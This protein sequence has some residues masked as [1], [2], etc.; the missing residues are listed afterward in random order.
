MM[1]VSGLDTTLDNTVRRMVQV[2]DIWGVV[3]T[4]ASQIVLFRATEQRHAERN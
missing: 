4:T 1:A 3:S 2:P